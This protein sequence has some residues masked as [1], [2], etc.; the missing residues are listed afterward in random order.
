MEFFT[1]LVFY[2]T[3][4]NRDLTSVIWFETREQ[5]SRALSVDEFIDAVYPDRKDVHVSCEVSDVMSRSIRPRLR[6][7]EEELDG[8]S[9]GSE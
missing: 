4:Q 2:Y 7:S 8:Q 9:V 6:P 5:C 1:A 3:V